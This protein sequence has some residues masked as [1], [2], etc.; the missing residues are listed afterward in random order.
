[1]KSINFTYATI[2]IMLF[3]VTLPFTSEAQI[4]SSL[5]GD[6]NVV[7]EERSTGD[8]NQ[9]QLNASADVFITQGNENQ[10]VVKADENLLEVIK[11]DI[12][13]N[14]LKIDVKGN[15]RGYTALEVH[16][17][18]KNLQKVLVN[19][20]GDVQSRNK[21]QVKDFEVSVNGSGDIDLDLDA[22]DVRTSING[23]G[24]VNLSG[25]NGNFTL[26]I[27]GSGDFAGN[28]FNLNNCSISVFGSGDVKISGNAKFVEIDQSAS[29]DTN[30]F[31]LQ[32]QD[33]SARIN[34]SGDVIVT[35]SKSLKGSLN[36]SGDL[37]YKG[38]PNMV[39]VSAKGS[40][41]VYKR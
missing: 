35:V 3:A 32:A 38:N 21:L 13:G 36:G 11:T 41:G 5:R 40:G 10:I 26:K 15:I 29:G 2:A 39:D 18:I 25:V 17:T 7:T 23:S 20:S 22:V 9:I 34:G 12:S 27:A 24:D 30:L 33:I 8:F 1:M 19:G 37:T 4:F 14:A 31:N 28:D 16:V 6:G